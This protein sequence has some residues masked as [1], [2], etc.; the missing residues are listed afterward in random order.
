MFMVTG[1]P[2][3]VQLLDVD[4]GGPVVVVEVVEV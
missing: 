3:D 2:R 4:G 1:F